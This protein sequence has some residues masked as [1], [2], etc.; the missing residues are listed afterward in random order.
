MLLGCRLSVRV[1]ERVY[2]TKI[3]M[4]AVFS[5]FRCFSLQNAEVLHVNFVKVCTPT[6]PTEVVRLKK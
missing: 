5:F 4:L 1:L 3:G 2:A 6:T